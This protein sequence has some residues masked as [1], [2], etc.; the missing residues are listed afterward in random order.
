[1]AG[2]FELIITDSRNQTQDLPATGKTLDQC[3]CPNLKNEHYF[4]SGSGRKDVV[5]PERRNV[6]AS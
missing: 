4:I 1:M 5:N 3:K 2:S 6:A